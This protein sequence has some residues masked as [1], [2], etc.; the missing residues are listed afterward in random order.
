MPTTS[1][2]IRALEEDSK[3][4]LIGP[5]SLVECPRNAIAATGTSSPYVAAMATAYIAKSKEGATT[6]TK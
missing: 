1:V 2:K 6:A 3:D 5:Q 4:K